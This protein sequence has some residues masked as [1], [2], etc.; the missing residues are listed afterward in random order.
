MPK[1]QFSDVVPPEKRSIRNIPIPQGGKRKTPVIIKPEVVQSGSKTDP[2]NPNFSRESSISAK[3]SE[4]PS[5][6]NS[7]PYEYYYPKDNQNNGNLGLHESGYGKV[8]VVSKKAKN[9]HFIFGGAAVVLIVAFVFFA[10]T[11]FASANVLIIPK[12]QDVAVSMDM[13]GTIEAREDSV[14]YEVLKLSKSKAVSLPATEEEMVEIKAHGKI[15]VYNN[16]STEPQRLIARTRF[17]SP[18]GLI[19]RIAESIIVPGQT[20]KE[21]VISPG[22]IETEVFADEAGEKYNIKKTDFTIPGFKNDPSRYKNFYARSSTDMEEGFVGKKKVVSEDQKKAAIQNLDE[23]IRL[24]L[25]KELLS[26]VPEGLVLLPGAFIYDSR[27]LPQTEESA[28]VVIS[29]EGTSYAIMLNKSDLSKK[30]TDQYIKDYPEWENIKST[31]YDF[32]SLVMD[33]KSSR[34]EAND[35]IEFRISGKA[36]ILADINTDLVSQKLAGM[37]RREIT[38]LLDEFA[39]ISSITTTIRPIWKQS[40]PK[41]PLK[42]NVKMVAPN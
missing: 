1:I 16:F 23:E 3:I 14:R 2:V 11:I 17:E 35:K 19:Y 38:K 20:M 29:Q 32:S 39:G 30:I 10:M 18:E 26:K 22:S 33:S 36:Q 6:S 37:S 28:S 27:N 40:F 4:S 12:S 42:I 7:G 34:I 5:K 8:P 31:V 24:D 21:G 25:E 9:K 13:V 41:N 15:V